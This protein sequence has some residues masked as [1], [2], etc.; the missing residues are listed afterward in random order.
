MIT[1]RTSGSSNSQPNASER[2]FFNSMTLSR[3]K[4]IILLEKL[5]YILDPFPF[6]IQ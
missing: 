3:V 4:E 6:N 1:Y 5:G 2:F